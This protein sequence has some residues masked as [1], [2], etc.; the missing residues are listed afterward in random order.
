MCG[1]SRGLAGSGGQRAQTEGGG[2]QLFAASLRPGEEERRARPGG[3]VRRGRTAAGL[4]GESGW[5]QP[6]SAGMRVAR[7][8]SQHQVPA[9]GEGLGPRGCTRR[10]GPPQGRRWCSWGAS[11]GRSRC[12]KVG[13]GS[14]QPPC[15]DRVP[16]Q[17]RGRAGG[18]RACLWAPRSARVDVVLEGN[19]WGFAG[20]F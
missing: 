19:F 4:R 8:G 16:A 9:G 5:P 6:R 20:L 12:S 10:A 13:R 7:P 1:H 11:P 18:S 15:S 17:L 3:A 2:R 14:G